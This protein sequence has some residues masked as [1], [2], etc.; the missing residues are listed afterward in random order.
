VVD[1]LCRQR[2][3]QAVLDVGTGT[4]LLARIARGRGARFVAGTDVDPAALASARAH[5]S[6]DA[7]EVEIHFNTAAPDHWGA[8]F[9]LVVANILEAPLRLLAP[10]LSRALRPGGILL[11]SGFTRMQMPALRVLYET[12]DLSYVRHSGLDEW[13]LLAFRPWPQSRPGGSSSQ[14]TGGRDFMRR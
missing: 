14:L 7:H 11:L 2:E 8:R 1:L 12:L 5:S 13:T 9:D 3:P 10:A 4:G 6:L